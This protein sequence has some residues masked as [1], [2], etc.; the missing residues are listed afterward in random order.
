[1]K[2]LFYLAVLACLPLLFTGCEKRVINTDVTLYG[3]VYDSDT[4]APIQGVMITLQPS[5]RNAYTGSDGTY[6]FDDLD[7]SVKKYTV[8]ATVE[9]YVTDRKFLTVKDAP[10]ETLE[11]SFALKRE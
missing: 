8:T 5:N 3:T 11:L 6:Q 9:G 10:G 1:M 2:K 7:I 4:R